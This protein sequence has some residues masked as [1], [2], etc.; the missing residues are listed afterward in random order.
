M[1]YAGHDNALIVK[2]IQPHFRSI[3]VKERGKS[4]IFM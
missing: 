1:Q 4:R 3:F 2:Q